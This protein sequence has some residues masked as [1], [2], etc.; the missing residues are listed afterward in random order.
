MS[1]PTP[2]LCPERGNVRAEETK[3]GMHTQGLEGPGATGA[4]GPR[5]SAAP[6]PE[7]GLPDPAHGLPTDH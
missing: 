2:G 3:E 6:A 1:I 4:V 7:R 5:G